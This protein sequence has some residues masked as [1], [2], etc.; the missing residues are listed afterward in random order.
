MKRLLSTEETH[1]SSLDSPSPTK[2]RKTLQDAIDGLEA[3]S[4]NL[5]LNLR[6]ALYSLSEGETQ[7]VKETLMTIR[8]TSKCA[9]QQSL[10]LM[11]DATKMNSTI[12][13]KMATMQKYNS[14]LVRERNDFQRRLK[15]AKE[16][17]NELEKEMIE[18]IF[19]DSS[20]QEDDDTTNVKEN[21][22]N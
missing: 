5:D 19:S 14:H 18:K 12:Q 16:K 3:F 1:I 11:R 10:F 6:A 22:N 15:L 21:D 4:H 7:Q 20:F 17:N 9:L 13:Q 8:R 2:H